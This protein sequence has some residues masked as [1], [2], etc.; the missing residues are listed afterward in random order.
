MT[1]EEEAF[2]EDIRDLAYALLAA[3]TYAERNQE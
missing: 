3:A 2:A 1:P